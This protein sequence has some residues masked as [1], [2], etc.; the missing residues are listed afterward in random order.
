M[1]FR[2]GND[3]NFNHYYKIVEN[4]I[5]S[6]LLILAA[7][8]TMNSPDGISV[9]TNYKLKPGEESDEI[10]EEEKAG[11]FGRLKHLTNWPPVDIQFQDIT[12]TVPDVTCGK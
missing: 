4:N 10:V 5:Q 7:L 11:E 3:R 9:D 6:H 12:Q 1:T 2:L 8:S